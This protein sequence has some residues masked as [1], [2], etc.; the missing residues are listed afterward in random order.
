[1]V[2]ESL[3]E[4]CRVGVKDIGASEDMVFLCIV[5]N[6]SVAFSL[7]LSQRFIWQLKV[8]SSLQFIPILRHP[9]PA[10]YSAP[11]QIPKSGP[12]DLGPAL[13]CA[14]EKLFISCYPTILVKITLHGFPNSVLYIYISYS[15]HLLRIYS[16]LC[17]LVLIHGPYFGSVFDHWHNSTIQ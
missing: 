5:F 17:A 2:E 16:R 11:Q 6:F 10:S 9:V 14:F 3:N 15:S 13:S 7:H 8:T 4:R 1:M 12:L